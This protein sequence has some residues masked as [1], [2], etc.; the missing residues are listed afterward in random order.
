[1]ASR[2][3]CAA[4]LFVTAVIHLA[5]VPEHAREWPLAAMFFLVLAVVELVL[6][7]AVLI[8][9]GRALLLG[10]AVIS[11]MSTVLW[12]ASRTVGLPI[13]PEVFRPEVVAAPDLVATAL[14][15]L[16]AATFA[17]MAVR[18]RALLVPAHAHQ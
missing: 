16:A 18:T 3:L 15:T 1:M 11:V 10:G 14:E 7:V 12:A 8:R 6:A 2:R 4:A 5:V 9:T 17:R 13:G